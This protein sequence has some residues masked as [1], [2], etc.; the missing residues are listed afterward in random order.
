[1]KTAHSNDEDAS[2]DESADTEPGSDEGDDD[3]ATPPSD[4]SLS[5]T[6]D[7]DMAKQIEAAGEGESLLGSDDSSDEAQLAKEAVYIIRDE[8]L[9]DGNAPS[10]H[11]WAAGGPGSASDSNGDVDEDAEFWTSLAPDTHW[12]DNVMVS[13][14]LFKPQRGFASSP[15]PSFS[16]FFGSSDDGAQASADNS[17]DADDALTDDA[18][19][20][21]CSVISDTPLSEPLLAH[22]PTTHE[23][24]PADLRTDDDALPAAGDVDLRHAIPL[25]VIE[26]LD[27]RLIYARAGDGEA[28]FGSDGEFEFAGDSDDEYSSDASEQSARAAPRLRSPGAQFGALDA[29]ADADDGDT[30]DELPDEDMPYPRLLIGSIAPHGGRNARRAREMAARSRRS[31]P[32]GA[33]PGAGVHAGRVPPG[34]RARLHAVSPPGD[35]SSTD[36]DGPAAPADS[37]RSL[38]HKRREDDSES[39]FTKP[40]M[41][42][43]MP[44]SA[45]SI[46][47]AVIDGSGMAPSP[48]TS[49]HSLQQ[50][51]F[52]CKRA[53]SR[54]RDCEDRVRDGVSRKRTRSARDESALDLFR[55]GKL[56]TA[57]ETD[58]APG[59]PF[60]ARDKTGVD[61]D[62]MDLGD[63]LDEELLW[64]GSST[65]SDDGAG[66]GA[67]PGSSARKGSTLAPS[68]ALREHSAEHSAHARGGARLNTKAFARWNRIPMGAFRDAQKQ[69]GAASVAPTVSAAYMGP[70]QPRSTYLLTHPFRSARS[71]MPAAPL[72]ASAAARQPRRVQTPFRRS[73]S[74]VHDLRDAAS[75]LHRTLTDSATVGAPTAF[76]STLS[77]LLGPDA[78]GK[79]PRHVEVGDHTVVGGKFL[80]SPLLR[81]VKHAH[82]RSTA[83]GSTG[84]PSAACAMPGVVCDAPAE[85]VSPRKVTKREKREK[86]ARRE[87]LKRERHATLSPA[88][89]PATR[90]GVSE[91]AAGSAAATAAAAAA[92]GQA[93]AS[94][95]AAQGRLAGA[96]RWE[97][98][99]PRVAGLL[100]VRDQAPR[101]ASICSAD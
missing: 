59:I 27:G 37:R 88:D 10:P 25:L 24:G 90:A 29:P 77:S 56:G 64:E 76:G 85:G 36:S 60:A 94:G 81:P 20:E 57:P 41:G 44:A 11:T 35:S 99:L 49:R 84:A 21:T 16:D 26:D 100:N 22:L 86:I 17:D 53:A 55:A 31:S 7:S 70:Q 28:V 98:S 62:V 4:A 66:W 2:V 45:K 63:V 71:F 6:D 33:S 92:R 52:R 15:E 58:A 12:D 54:P 48:F 80:V 91:G 1:M 82:V 73:A 87:A 46:H 13:D 74:G 83:T 5:D 89:I 34:R 40:E 43:F 23:P 95:G 101:R 18:T 8:L 47:R 30:T 67:R 14:E 32:R 9:H 69:A 78:G 65:S 61:T 97:A 96:P 68:H 42:Q 93:A 38:L 51:G 75:P 39:D 3:A 19:T 79:G 50:H 72:S